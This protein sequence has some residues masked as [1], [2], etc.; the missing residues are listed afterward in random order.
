MDLHH[1]NSAPV[2]WLGTRRCETKTLIWRSNCSVHGSFQ[3]S[4]ICLMH[5]HRAKFCGGPVLLTVKNYQAQQAACSFF[6][7]SVRWF[8]ATPAIA[9]PARTR[10]GVD[11]K[12]RG[13][14]LRAKERH[15]TCCQTEAPHSAL[16]LAPPRSCI[17][18]SA[19]LERNRRS[20]HP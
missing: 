12:G 8:A 11:L 14:R 6:S 1:F 18:F 20:L 17:P 13:L 2:R 16:P 5:A 9:L 15:R 3:R 19:R 10:R 7:A 4:G